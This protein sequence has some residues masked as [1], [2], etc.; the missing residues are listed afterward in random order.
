MNDIIFNTFCIILAV[1]G[2]I[3]GIILF[4]KIATVQ[5]KKATQFNKLPYGFK[6]YCGG[7]FNSFTLSYPFVTVITEETTIFIKYMGVNI[8]LSFKDIENIEISQ[9]LVTYRL[10]IYHNVN[11]FPKDIK[12]FT[13]YSHLIYNFIIQQKEKLLP[14]EETQR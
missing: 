4:V 7:Q 12:L 2:T 13:P 1:G 8:L 3:F 11:G 5:K 6:F 9:D 10:R 14:I